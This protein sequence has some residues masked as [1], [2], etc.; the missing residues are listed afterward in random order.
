MAVRYLTDGELQ[1]LRYELGANVLL[2][3]AEPYIPHARVFD[4][5]QSNLASDAQAPAT[6]VT[7][8]TAIGSAKIELVVT[9]EAQTNWR[10]GIP[11]LEVKAGGSR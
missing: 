4:V 6:G 7:D 1:R 5:I 2:I 11:R 3:G 8:V 10:W 9:G